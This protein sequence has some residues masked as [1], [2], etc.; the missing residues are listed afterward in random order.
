MYKESVALERKFDE[1]DDTIK[2]YLP[3]L[4]TESTFSGKMRKFDTNA[5]NN[6]NLLIN[7]NIDKM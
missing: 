1:L 7:Q 2:K 5:T 6:L 4:D 3:P